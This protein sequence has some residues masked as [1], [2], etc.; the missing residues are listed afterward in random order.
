MAINHLKNLIAGIAFGASLAAPVLA[1]DSTLPTGLPA[2]ETPF[3]Q[4]TLLESNPL[5]QSRGIMVGDMETGVSQI[6][7]LLGRSR[8]E[9]QWAFV[10]AA[11][12]WVEIGHNEV[13]SDDESQVELDFE[14]LAKIIQTYGEVHIVHFHP[15]SFYTNGR[16]ADG[17]FGPCD[18]ADGLTDAEV[19]MIGF[20]LPSA[21]DVA[22]SVQ[23]VELL[24][25]AA[26]GSKLRFSVVSP[27]GRVEYGAGDFGRSQ[28]VI[29]Q[30][31]PR[32]NILSA[33]AT[34][35]AIRRSQRNIIRLMATLP[36]PTIGEVIAALC[37]QGSGETYHLQY[38]PAGQ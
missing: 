14:Y 8:F 11:N 23:L 31:N 12:F 21:A 35:S 28:I 37:V 27:L 9:E 22:A 30:G 18:R 4:L 13:V 38:Q 1:Q 6:S 20:T 3:L 17:M 33:L 19:T 26:L 7:A 36:N 15:A 16:W 32:K 2:S 25:R 5:N 10:P 29:N 24:G 34:S